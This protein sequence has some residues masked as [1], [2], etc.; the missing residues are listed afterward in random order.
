MKNCKLSNSFLYYNKKLLTLLLI[1]LNLISSHLQDSV[2]TESTLII[3]ILQD[4]KDNNRLDCLRDP[5]PPPRDRL[6][7]EEETLI[8]LNAA[9]DTDCSFEADYN[10]L[11]ILKRNFALSTGLVDVEGASVPGNIPEQAD[12]CEIIR[13][14]IAGGKFEGYRLDNLD[15][16]I[17]D[18]ISCPGEEQGTQVCAAT[19]GNASQSYGWYI[20]LEG[21]SI[22]ID[23]KPAWVMTGKSKMKLG[24][25]KNDL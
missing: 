16:Q 23:S 15:N 7:S 5:L 9:W 24:L 20:F 14:L 1:T 12:M 25:Y 3:E 17:V 8:R 11:S 22:T 18:L 4:L 6:E 2:C 21:E 13:A 10:W 19:G